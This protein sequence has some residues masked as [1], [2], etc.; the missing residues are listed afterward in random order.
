MVLEPIPGKLITGKMFP[1]ESLMQSHQTILKRTL[2]L[3]GS[4]LGLLIFP[5]ILIPVAIAIRISSPGPVFYRQLR[6]G[7]R[8]H[9]FTCYKFRTMYRGTG[10]ETVYRN[11]PRVTP[12]GAF[13]R[14]TSLDELPQL[15]NVFLGQMSLV[16]PRPHMITHTLFYGSLI[17]GYSE[18]LAVKPGITGL[19]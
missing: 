17:D 19:A 11:D 15:L 4:T 10:S 3:A 13:L 18:R 5:I 2:D 7:R 9:L 14:R 1:E 6:T 12:I 16:G 8:G